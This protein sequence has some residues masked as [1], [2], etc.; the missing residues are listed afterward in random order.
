MR[1][2]LTY[3]LWLL[4]GFA[5]IVGHM[6][7]LFLKFKGGKGVAT[8]AGVILGLFPYY[9]LPALVAII[10]F[11]IVIKVSRYVSVASMLGSSA[12]PL[13]YISMGLLWRPP[14]PIF[15]Q[16]LPL[17]LFA[18]LMAALIVFKHRGNLS[19]LK[20]GTEP[21]VGQKAAKV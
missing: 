20:K 21:R 17:L 12:F 2:E 1:G 6:F 5:A 16:Q 14:W 15:G 18:V 3:L 11:L 8:N 10:V 19:R 4:I 7:S 13:A 9:T